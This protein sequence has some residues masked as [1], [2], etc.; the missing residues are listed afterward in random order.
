MLIG[1]RF[2][3][4]RPCSFGQVKM[5]LLLALDAFDGPVSAFFFGGTVQGHSDRKTGGRIVSDDL[6]AS[7]SL[8]PWPLPNGFQASFS[9]SRVA[10]S[11]R[12]PAPRHGVLYRPPHGPWPKK[13]T[14]AV[15]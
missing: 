3:P 2:T 15:G 6:Y 10:Q 1:R 12:L 14:F 5:P 13:M 7:H 8:A 11:D 4:G 9:E